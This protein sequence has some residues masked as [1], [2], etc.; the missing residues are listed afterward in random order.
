MGTFVDETQGE[1]LWAQWT[2][3]IAAKEPGV[4]PEFI[5]QPK[6]DVG[7]K[8]LA[9]IAAGDAPDIIQGTT[10]EYAARGLL[11]DLTALLKQD[12]I[13][14]TRSYFKKPVA[15]AQFNGRFWSM[16]GGLS[17]YVFW[18]NLDMLRASG[19]EPPKDG[20]MTFDDFVRFCKAAT[21]DTTGTGRTDQWGYAADNWFSRM[22]PLI[23]ANGGDMFQYNTAYNLLTK[24][25][26][27]LGPTWEAIQWQADLV[28]KQ[29]VSPAPSD[30]AA[31]KASTFEGGKMLLNYGGGWLISTYRQQIGDKF[32]WAALRTPT[33]NAGDPPL[34]MVP[35]FL[36]G[37]ILKDTKTR[38]AAWRALRY[39][40]GPEGNVGYRTYVTDELIFDT[41]PEI[42]RYV[43]QSP[44]ANTQ[45]LVDAAREA[46]ERPFYKTEVR[47]LY[48]WASDMVPAMNAAFKP[49]YEGQASAKDAVAKLQPQLQ[50]I[51]DKGRAAGYDPDNPNIPLA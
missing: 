17:A 28:T 15:A 13:L 19:I 11:I 43:S 5:V 41:P 49:I 1:K 21:R 23:W 22:P 16:P 9:Q 42:Q 20:R 31:L 46:G 26:W 32:H 48:G 34:E 6:T 51:I 8:L 33:K 35:A 25:T 45:L 50:N 44:S 38:D 10:I 3:E 2:R 37:S 47:A 18:A 29:R 12:K 39:I 4:Q 27:D 40:S 30:A 14:E 7:D 24:P 36:R